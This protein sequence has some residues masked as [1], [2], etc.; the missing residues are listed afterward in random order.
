MIDVNLLPEQN[1]SNLENSRIKKF[2]VTATM[3]FSVIWWLGVGTV[4][5]Y[6]Q[7]LQKQRSTLETE[8]TNSESRINAL[9][10]LGNDLLILSQKTSGIE[11]LERTRFDFA[12]SLQYVLKL[13][14]PG[15]EISRISLDE[16]G[17]VTFSGRSPTSAVVSSFLS[18]LGVDQT[19]NFQ[20]L[21]SLRF[22]DDGNFDFTITSQYKFKEK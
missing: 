4:F 13:F 21:T 17:E 1:V 14:P 15:I 9:H 7:I 8:I 10:R 19:L 6:D 18:Q 2:A 20:R 12:G 11:F 16:S 22:S 3:I 5:V